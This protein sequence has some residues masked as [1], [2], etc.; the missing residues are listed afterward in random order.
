M[1]AK[2]SERGAI[3]ITAAAGL[4]T[5]I[6]AAALAVDLG[7]LV[8][9]RR[10]LQAVADLAA[11]DAVRS[12]GECVVDP[13]DP[14]A[15]AAASAIRNGSPG[16]LGSPPSR[17]DVG[18]IRSVDGVREF[19]PTASLAT[20]H[21]VR[22]EAVR[23]VSA[24][25]LAGAFLPGE[26]RLKAVGVARQRAAAALRA[27]AS[28]SDV[29]S[30]G[31]A[32]LDA[33]LGGLLG[34]ALS[35]DAAAYRTLVDGAV[36][37]GDLLD[38][39]PRIERPAALL[40]AE[41]SFDEFLARMADALDQRG[42]AAALVVRELASQLAAGDA[43][44]VLG[45]LVALEPGLEEE[46]RQANLS[47]FDLVMWG[48]QVASGAQTI[49]IDPPWTS[50]P[51]IASARLRLR[52]IEPPRIAI[53]PPGGDEGGAWWT[54]VRSPRFRGEIELTASE[55]VP[56]LD[57]AIPRVQIFVELAPATARLESID[58]ARTD[59]PV[60]RVVVGA[61]PGEARIGV[62]HYESFDAAPVASMLVSS[63]LPSGETVVV[64]AEAEIRIEE[65]E[66][67]LEL[68]GPFPPQIAEP[69][70]EN[71]RSVGSAL[72][73]AVSGA[74]GDV[75]GSTTLT[76]VGSLPAGIPPNELVDQV[77]EVLGTV[78]VAA[79][80]LVTPLLGALGTPLGGED[81]TVRMVKARPPELVR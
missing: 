4:A 79:S 12:F 53:G 2:R 15:A 26:V 63:S 59:D 60:H 71:T 9:S 18:R 45:Q 37:L 67:M 44:L 66:R 13:G 69:S 30:R 78:L 10:D 76:V 49:T 8:W 33:V 72:D 1:R 41:L 22:V 29:D 27:G 6:L 28:P 3:S 35:L 16:D 11:I 23:D 21:A 48:A 81:V 74:L 38:A 50:L 7:R 19:E 57:G 80:E 62:G 32:L 36:T 77:S 55:G 17:V 64:Q 20:A 25:L 34:G 70:P 56:L 54:E 52:V 24:A 51:G 40:E 47:A 65:G 68:D 39:E 31:A 58:C 42:D 14:V 43:A 61:D 75:A 46:A 73:A 5:A